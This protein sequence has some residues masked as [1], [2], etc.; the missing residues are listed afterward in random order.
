M[1]KKS[2]YQ[3]AVERLNSSK[4]SWDKTANANYNRY[5]TDYANQANTIYKRAVANNQA[6]AKN[7]LNTAYVSNALANT[8]MNDN[9]KRQGITGG[10][11]ETSVLNQ[12]NNYSNVQAGINNSLASNNTSAANTMNDNI[13]NYNLTNNQNRNEELRTNKDRYYT[14]KQNAGN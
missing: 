2:S 7:S 11:S 10:A 14:Q 4:K 6:T 5:A 1:A 13:A 3:K 8:R 9:L 12:A